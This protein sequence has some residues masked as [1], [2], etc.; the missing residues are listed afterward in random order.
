MICVLAATRSIP[1]SHAMA[2]HGREQ[3]GKAPK[4]GP[5]PRIVLL[6]GPGTQILDVAGPAEV[7]GRVERVLGARPGR[8]RGYDVVLVSTE[9]ERVST[10]CGIPLVSHRR[11]RDLRGPVDTL[12]IAGGPDTATRTHDPGI[13]GW[14]RR[15]ASRVRRIGSVCTGAFILAEAGL[16]RHRRATT[17]WQWCDELRRRFPA[18]QV[19]ADRIFV[20]DHHVYT[21]AGITAGIDL[22][23]ALVEEDH[24]ADVALQVA[25]E[26]VLFLR[27]PGGQTQFSSALKLS[28]AP[29]GPLRELQAWLLEHLD[30]PL[31]V[32]ALAKEAAMSPRNFA[33]VFRRDLGVTPA[34]FIER[35][36]VEAARR[37]LEEGSESM[38]EVAARCGFG[39]ADS[40]RRSFAR[41]LG[42]RPKDYRQLFRT[43]GLHA[44][45]R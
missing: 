5:R 18:T 33:R 39:T 30:Q 15:K 45:G 19:E 43:A 32:E 7:F 10:S 9:S 25:R 42:T 20:R 29:T 22:A 6:A 27:R 37:R 2:I 44:S 28:A 24:G 14:L 41:V 16:L 4:T 1:Y 8:R 36:R 31:A 38:D 23:L 34:R 11:Y 13:L 3:S 17:H 26:L 12:L 35:L 40:L 21:S